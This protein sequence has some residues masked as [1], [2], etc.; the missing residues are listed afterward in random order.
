MTKDEERPQFF[1]SEGCQNH[2][3]AVRDALYVLNGKW[4]IPVIAALINGPLRFNE[5]QQVLGNI[6]P[7]VLSNELREL[8][9]N[10]LL[11]RRVIAS[12]PVTVIYE[13]TDYSKSLSGVLTHLR[14]W[15]EQHKERIIASRRMKIKQAG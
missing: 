2:L 10:E 12:V 1:S 4:K 9:L 14:M 6:S 11:T 15:G 7:K 8:E 3:G 5:L 13:L